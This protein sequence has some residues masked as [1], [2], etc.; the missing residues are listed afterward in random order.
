MPSIS[1]TIL[2]PSVYAGSFSPVVRRARHSTSARAIFSPPRGAGGPRDRA[3]AA[4][5]RRAERGIVV[6]MRR[7]RRLKIQRRYDLVTVLQV[8]EHL[9]TPAPRSG[10]S[11]RFF[12]R[13]RSSRRSQRRIDEARV[14]GVAW[15]PRPSSSPVHFST[16][17]SCGSWRRISRSSRRATVHAV[18]G[19]VA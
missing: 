18:A 1:T 16:S 4:A 2:P 19:G 10:R 5:R 7:S 13:G 12:A 3:A 9:P 17:D 15:F 8:L 14:T 6:E 11:A